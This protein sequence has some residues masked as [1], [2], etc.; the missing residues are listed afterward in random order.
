MRPTA[1]TESRTGGFI[2][3]PWRP[4]FQSRRQ[5]LRGNATKVG[6]FS[7]CSLPRHDSDRW[8]DQGPKPHPNSDGPTFVPVDH[9]YSKDR[10]H[11]CFTRI[12]MDVVPQTGEARTIP[13]PD[14]D[15]ATFVVLENGYARSASRDCLHG[16]QVQ[17]AG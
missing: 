17:P 4:A 5:I 14:A 16:V 9:H 3:W 11:V 1:L 6:G 12:V 10:T 2:P 7:R 15:P 8:R 13:L